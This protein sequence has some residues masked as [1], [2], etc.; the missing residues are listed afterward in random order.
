VQAEDLSLP[1]FRSFAGAF[2]I[3]RDHNFFVESRVDLPLLHYEK[4]TLSYT[5]QESTPFLDVDHG[6][7][8]SLL[9]ARNELQLE[10]QPV[11]WLRVFALGGYRRSGFEDRA[12]ELS[13]AVYG[14][15]L[16]SPRRSDEERWR[17]LVWMGG[18]GSRRGL[19]GRWWANAESSLL[20]FDFAQDRYLGSKFRASA[21]LSGELDAVATDSG[22]HGLYQIGPEIRFYTANSNR[23]NLQARWYYNDENP[24]Y[25]FDENGLLFGFQ[26]SSSHDD[27]YVL[28]ARAKRQPGWFPLVWGDYDVGVGHRRS[29]TR[30]TMNVEAVDFL[31]L[32]HPITLA[33]WY[34]N[35]Q[36][37]RRGDYDHVS[38]S[39]TFGLQ[40]PVGLESPLSQG[41]PLV[42][43]LD[44]YHRSDHALDPNADRVAT[45]GTATS[46][47]PLLENGSMNLL[48]R[49]RL[50]TI[51][52]DLPYRDP[53]MFERRT[54]WLNVV[55][56]RVTAGLNVESSRERGPF[57]GQLGAVWDIAT[58]DGFVAYLKAIGSVGNEGPDWLVETGVRRP[59]G[60]LFARYENYGIDHDLAQGPAFLIGCGVNL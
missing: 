11:D 24:F 44:F 27:D 9:Y 30:F 60:R 48:P 15:G 29:L 26:V 35:R 31:V 19:E 22:F 28:H 4:W 13:A 37:Y 52:W 25:G 10:L 51:G 8:A 54:A 16:G 18:Y 32:N 34:E 59:V 41:D 14:V 55:N 36:E 43:G 45:R 33:A 57:A 53:A 50:Q 7:R 12:G 1:T 5:H 17:W 56:W 20:L 47:G 3:S 21:M 38:Y 6:V 46:I 39:V 23:A 58:I 2:L 49:L 40:S 42:A